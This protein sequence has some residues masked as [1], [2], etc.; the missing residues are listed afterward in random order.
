MSSA[1]RIFLGLASFVADL[2][3]CWEWADEE[4]VEGV[5]EDEALTKSVV[6]VDDLGEK[7]LLMLAEVDFIVLRGMRGGSMVVLVGTG[8]SQYAVEKGSMDWMVGSEKL[9]KLG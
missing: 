5:S 9:A 1:E 4:R 2:V 3:G 6:V 8:E 7:R